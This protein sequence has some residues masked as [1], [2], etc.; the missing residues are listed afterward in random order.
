MKGNKKAHHLFLTTI[1]TWG[2]I[3]YLSGI[4]IRLKGEKH[5]MADHGLLLILYHRLGYRPL[6]CGLF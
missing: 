3:S 2:L 6:R 5:S 4:A 1:I